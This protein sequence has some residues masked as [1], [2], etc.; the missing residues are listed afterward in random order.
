MSKSLKRALK[1]KKS[2]NIQKHAVHYKIFN[3]S[4]L[5][6]ETHF[7]FTLLFLNLLQKMRKCYKLHN[8][9]MIT[10]AN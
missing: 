10:I 2:Q 1:T 9:L 4:S 8:L 3:L 7:K 6:H 5:Y